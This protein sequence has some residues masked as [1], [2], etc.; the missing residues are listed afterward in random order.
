MG[1]LFA[2]AR[3]D[4]SAYCPGE[5]VKVSAYVNNQS[6]RQVIATEVHLVQKS[7]FKA[8]RG[9]IAKLD[10][11]VWRMPTDGVEFGTWD[12]QFLGSVRLCFLE[13]GI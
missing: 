9:T 13:Q 6:R 1:Q 4:R 7:V 2:R 12:V 8:P 11:V 10:L 5:E 3:I